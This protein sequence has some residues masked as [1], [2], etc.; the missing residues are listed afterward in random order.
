MAKLSGEKPE[1]WLKTKWLNSKM[2]K[3]KMAKI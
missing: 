3:T 1:K 2:A